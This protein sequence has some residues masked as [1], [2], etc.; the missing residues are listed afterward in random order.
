M[1]WQEIPINQPVYTNVNDVSL[2]GRTPERYNTYRN[3]AGATVR[4]PGYSLWVDLGTQK[5]IDGLYAWQD[6]VIAVSDGDIFKVDLQGNVTTLGQHL[7]KIGNR[8]SFANF[9]YT[10]YAA[11]GGGIAKITASNASTLTDS[12]IPNKVSHII[13]YDTYMVALEVG[14]ARIHRSDVLDPET[15]EGNFITAEQYPDDLVALKEAWGEFWGFGRRTIERFYNDDVTPFRPIDGAVIPTGCCAPHTIQWVRG[16][17]YWLNEH[18][19]LVRSSGQDYEVISTPIQNILH[20]ARQIEDAIGDYVTMGGQSFYILTLPSYQQEGLT[21]VY[22][23]QKNEWQGKWSHWDDINAKHEMFRGNAYGFVTRWNKHVIGDALTG[24]LYSFSFDY[25]MDDGEMIRSV[26]LTGHID[27]GTH[28]RKRSFKLRFR[29]LRGYGSNN[30]QLMIR[31]RDDGDRTWGNTYY[32]D[33]GN[34]GY[35]E[36]YLSMRR[37]GMYR[38]RQYEISVTD[39]VP[40]VLASAEEDVEALPR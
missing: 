9:G 10:L 39:D 32:L 24:Y 40:I 4:R 14:T 21:L 17:F 15:W 5:P 11:N 13:S 2:T 22:D 33:L 20:D 38:S 23:L 18:R 26:W 8:P 29:L 27:H 31:W 25:N 36:F 1:T 7:L 30:P 28:R 35:Y 37:L 34:T 19:E 12:D 3:D 16:G 6:L